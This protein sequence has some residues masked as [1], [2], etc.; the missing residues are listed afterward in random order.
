MGHEWT[1]D[2][3]MAEVRYFAAEEIR[4]AREWAGGG[5]IAIHRNF[6]VD[7]MVVGGKVR[8]GA[9]WHVLGPQDALLEWGLA[10]HLNPSWLQHPGDPRRVHWDV[11]G[12]LARKLERQA[13]VQR[14]SLEDAQGQLKLD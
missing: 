2:A 6:D 13:E 9:A 12:A 14:Q 7:G 1:Y 5:G 11:F 10:H 4:E 8:Q 3:R